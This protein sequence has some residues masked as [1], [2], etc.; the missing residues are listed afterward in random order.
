MVTV[1]SAEISVLIGEYGPL[2]SSFFLKKKGRKHGKCEKER[3]D[4]HP[5]DSI[6]FT[7]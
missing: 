1:C 6:N 5:W 3:Y 7:V 2:R 4:S